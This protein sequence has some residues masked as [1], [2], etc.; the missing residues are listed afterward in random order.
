[1]PPARH[2]TTESD[3][4]RTPPCSDLGAHIDGWI[5]SQATSLVV[6]SDPEAPVTGRP[7]DVISAAHTAMEAALRLVRPGL[8]ISAV[9]EV[10]AKVRKAWRSGVVA[11]VEL[12]GRHSPPKVAQKERARGAS[13]EDCG[14][15]CRNHLGYMQSCITVHNVY[16]AP[17]S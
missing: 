12:M 10:L 16:C 8:K 5:A 9:S 1:M 4:F 17:L 11:G 13:P 6:Q 14:V 15:A 2:D 3:I 7:A